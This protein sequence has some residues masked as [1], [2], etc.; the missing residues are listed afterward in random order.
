MTATAARKARPEDDAPQIVSL[1]SV[2]DRQEERVVLFEINDRQYSIPTKVA[3][4]KALRYLHIGRT[5]GQE[6]QIDFMLGVLLGEEGYEAL[7]GFD[8]LTEDNLMDVVKACQKVM[9]GA[10]EVPKGKH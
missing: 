5:Q 2:P 9:T 10:V 1:R 4:N 3:T 6:A 8:D 7:M